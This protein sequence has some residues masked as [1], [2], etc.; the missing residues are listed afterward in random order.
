ML[1]LYRLPSICSKSEL[2]F[3]TQTP[4]LI[5]SHNEI[6]VLANPFFHSDYPNQL[7]SL[8]VAT[9][10]VGCQQ[11][12]AIVINLTEGSLNLSY[13][14]LSPTQNHFLQTHDHLQ[15]NINRSTH[16]ESPAKGWQI[17]LF[18]FQCDQQNYNLAV[19]IPY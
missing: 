1:H 14:L 10:I 8:K 9:N 5:H 4:T 15:I 7:S 13:F 18:L 6:F 16:R 11:Y 17:K 19:V 12:L 3:E 2:H